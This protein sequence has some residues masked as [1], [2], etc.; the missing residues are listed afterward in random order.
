MFRIPQ[1]HR[2]DRTLAALLLAVGAS[3]GLAAAQQPAYAPSTITQ[4]ADSFPIL[5][6]DQL[7]T[8]LGSIALYPDPL[9]AQILPAATYPID[10]VRAA[11]LVRSGA[12][13]DQIDQQPWDPSVKAITRAI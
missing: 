9:I 7:D 10:I 8:L 11:R 1:H 2:A 6:A 13:T 4:P 3:A 12:N 5:A